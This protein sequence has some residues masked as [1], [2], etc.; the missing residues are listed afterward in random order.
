MA[1]NLQIDSEK[2]DHSVPMLSLSNAFSKEKVGD[3]VKKISNFLN[4]KNSEKIV[5]SA[6]AQKSMEFQRH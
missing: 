4:L 6:G 2:I 1:I 3:F 5:F